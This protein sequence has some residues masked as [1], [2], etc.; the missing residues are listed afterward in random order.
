MHR[1]PNDITF[2][3]TKIMKN[4]Q[5][6]LKLHRSRENVEMLPTVT[7]LTYYANICVRV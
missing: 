2:T 1:R 6:C 4:I 3:Q 7:A 5:I